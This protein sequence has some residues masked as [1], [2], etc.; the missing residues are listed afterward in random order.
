LLLH[1]IKGSQQLSPAIHES[2]WKEL[3]DAFVP[4]MKDETEYLAITA[5]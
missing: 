4:I 5:W 2:I 1:Q 3:M